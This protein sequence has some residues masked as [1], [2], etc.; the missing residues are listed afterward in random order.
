MNPSDPY[1]QSPQTPQ[2]Q[3][4]P[5]QPGA[6][7]APAQQYGQPQA[8]DPT[9]QFDFIMNPQKPAKKPVLLP[10]GNSQFGKL[11]L[12]LGGLVVLVILV[13]VVASL[14]GGKSPNLTAMTTVAQD[15]AELARVAKLGESQATN[16]TLSN[17]AISIDLTALSANQQLVSYLATNGHK[18]GDKELSLKRDSRTDTQLKTAED[19]SNF[20]PTYAGVLET[21]LNTYQHDLKTAY[22]SAT[23]P[24]G[25]A[26]LSSEYTAAGLLLKQLKQQ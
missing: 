10:G 2:P 19:A 4:A 14:M 1:R 23:G 11:A 5:S 6:L 25:R 9:Q 15:Q 22:A 16:Q 26:L 12:I 3:A 17:A 20:D 8:H 18:L 13:A 24:K 21:Q 7:P